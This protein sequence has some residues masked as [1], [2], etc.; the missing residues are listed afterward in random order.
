MRSVDP[1]ASE[2]V[3][4]PDQAPS[5]PTNGR[6]W[7]YPAETDKT[8]AAATAA[9]FMTCPNKPEPN[10]FIL[11]FPFACDLRRR[12]VHAAPRV[13]VAA[14]GLVQMINR[15]LPQFRQVA[16]A[17]LHQHRKNLQADLGDPY[18]SLAKGGKLRISCG[19]ALRE[20][21]REKNFQKMLCDTNYLC[22][23]SEWHP[24]AAICQGIAANL[25]AFDGA[26]VAFAAALRGIF[27][28]NSLPR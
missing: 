26:L 21:S 1:S 23:P 8:S 6:D 27:D 18:F 16:A 24:A 20:S 3:P 25:A 14:M 11:S 10:R 4:L 13:G 17:D 15:S 2:T 5:K 22:S 19:L 7:A 12:A 28:L 9:A